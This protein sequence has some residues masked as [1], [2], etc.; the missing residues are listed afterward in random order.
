MLRT[1]LTDRF[2]LRYPVLSAPMARHSGARLAAA[3][4]AAGGLGTFG[5]AGSSNEWLRAQIEAVR[6]AT[7]SPFGVGFLTHFLEDESEAALFDLTL[8]AAPPAFV[9]SFAD[10]APWIARTKALGAA[11]FCQVQTPASAAEAVAA[12]A[13]VLIAQGSQAGG[14]CGPADLFTLLPELLERYPDIPVLA[15][16][17]IASARLIAAVLAAGAD[18]VMMGTRFLASPEAVEVSDLHKQ[19]ITEAAVDDTVFSYAFDILTGTPWP[20]G[21]GAR[22]YR[23][24]FF[25]R[26]A[27]REDEMSR[28]I[29]AVR[30]EQAALAERDSAQADI[31]YMGTSAGDIASVQPVA[32]IIASLFDEAERLLR[33]NVAGRLQD[34]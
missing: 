8:D 17:G 7:A 28:N 18:G 14:H 25:Q 27:G 11:A 13:D 26:W 6:T 2:G 10:P 9:F 29:E 30:A 31:F 34:H 5:A 23:N 33:S 32:T 1:R 16:G 24:R 19:V 12:G 3:V 4:S 20:E 15:A 21:I 22:G